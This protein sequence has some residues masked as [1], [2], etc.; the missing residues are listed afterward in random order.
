[1]DSAFFKNMFKGDRVLWSIFGVMLVISVIVM[2]S[3]SSALAYKSGDYNAPAL[4]HM[5]FL[6]GAV[7][8]STICARINRR[9]ILS[10]GYAFLSVAVVSLIYTSFMGGGVEENNASRWLEIFG[11][12]FQPSELAKLGLI[13]V[14]S[15]FLSVWQTEDGV[16]DRCLKWSFGIT[17]LVCLAI[18]KENFSTAAILFA[19]VFVL[20]FVG[21]ARLK[22]LGKILSGIVALVGIV[23]LLSYVAG[24]FD[25]EV[26]GLPRA[27]T[28]VSRV[29]R[30]FDRIEK[31]GSDSYVVTDDTRQIDYATM[32]IANSDGWGVGPGNSVMRDHIP[33]AYADFIYAVLVEEYGLLGGLIVLFLYLSFFY[34][35]VMVACN[36]GYMFGALFCIGL[37]LMILVQAFAHIMVCVGIFPVTGQ[38]LPFISHGGTSILMMSIYVGLIQNV[39]SWEAKPAG[40]PAKA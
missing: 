5:L 13:V 18:F 34:R 2:F 33:Y 27:E 35:S 14:L 15:Y 38:P 28:W 40:E 37:S 29:S 8:I 19:V 23:F 6:G 31:K 25:V 21:Q 39:A 12:R 22:T 32:A 3:A 7:I 17:G 10:L 30:H 9:A 24:K 16:P 11:I 20:H 26:P 1:M 4:R 36:C